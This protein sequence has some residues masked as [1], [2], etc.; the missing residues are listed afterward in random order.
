MVWRGRCATIVLFTDGWDP[1]E[2]RVCFPWRARSPADGVT[3]SV[4]G[5]G[6]GPGP[7]L[8]RMAELGGGRY[9]PGV[10]LD[11]VPEIFVEETLLVAEN[12][13]REGVFFPV[14]SGLGYMSEILTGDPGLAGL[15]GHQGQGNRHRLPGSG[16]G[17]SAAGV[18][19]A[20]AGT[21]GGVDLRRHL[22]LE[23][24]VG[25]MA[26]L[27]GFL[28]H[29]GPRDP[30]GAGRWGS[31]RRPSRGGVLSIGVDQPGLPAE[32]TGVA[33]VRGP[34]GEVDVI[35]LRR[36]APDTFV[37]K[38]RADTAG[39]YWITA[40][41]N[42]PDGGRNLAG[43]VSGLHLSGGVL[44]PASRPGSRPGNRRGHRRPGRPAAAQLLRCG[45]HPGSE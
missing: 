8:E 35:S 45:R 4:L 30:A 41:I 6:E 1:D 13:V 38:A 23:F 43:A 22:P 20:G 44:I 33:R 11:L 37:A 16:C 14:R 32:A 34:D 7:T 17:T 10:D 28:G 9:Y 26:R 19:A 29:G 31:S 39:A 25:G 15:R 18:L 5:T 36:V 24:R 12:L 40:D 42:T 2:G 3:L 21:G 27:R